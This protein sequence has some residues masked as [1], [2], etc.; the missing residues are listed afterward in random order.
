MLTGEKKSQQAL[1]KMHGKFDF[2]LGNNDKNNH[3]NDSSIF[4]SPGTTI[5][6]AILVK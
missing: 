5:C 2:F 4:S 3:V 6:S 1:V